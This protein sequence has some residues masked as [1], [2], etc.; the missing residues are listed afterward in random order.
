MLPGDAFAIVL[1]MDHDLYEDEDDDFCCGRAYGGSRVAVV[2]TA[3]YHPVLDEFAGIDYS[4]MWPASHCKTYADGLCAG[5]GLK[6][7]T[8]GSGVPSSSASPLRRAIDAASRT[9]PNLAAE[10]HRALWFSRLAR[11]VVHE[12]GHCLGMGHC[13]YYACVMQGTSGMAEDVRQPPYLCPVRLAKI[14][15]AVAGEL[16]CGSDTEKARYVKAR[17]DGLADFCGRWQ[18][19]GM[20]A[21]YEAWLRARLEDLSSSEK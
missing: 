1:L 5:K 12:L 14:T 8:S 10:D 9:N 18:H 4:H 16:G 6:V 13:T 15:H 19:V 21:G 2:S 17:Y 7:T 11:T 3:R 20:F